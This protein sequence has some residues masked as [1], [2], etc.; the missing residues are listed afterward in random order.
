MH[1]V[2]NIVWRSESTKFWNIENQRLLMTDEFS[3]SINAYY[4]QFFQVMWWQTIII[5]TTF[6]FVCVCVCVCMYSCEQP[7]MWV[8]C[9]SCMTMWQEFSMQKCKCAWV[10]RYVCT[11]IYIYIYTY[12]CHM[13][14][15]LKT[16][17]PHFRLLTTTHTYTHT[18]TDTK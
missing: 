18:H 14:I 16:Q 8:L 15:Q 11:Y 3:G 1:F 12:C 9:F 7:K 2:W 13:V 17:D 10:L 4:T 6:Y 5:V